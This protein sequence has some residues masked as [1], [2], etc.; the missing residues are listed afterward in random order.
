MNENAMRAIRLDKVVVNTGVGEAG[1]KLQKAEKVLQMVTGQK[2]FTTVSRSTIRDWGI[3][4]NMRIGAKVTLRGPAADAF[5]RRALEVRNNRLP[6][7]SFDARGNFSFGIADHTD[8][9]GM[10]YDPEIGVVGMDVSVA[11]R[12]PGYRVAHRRVRRR[13]VSTSHRVTRKESIAFIHS[14]YNVEVVE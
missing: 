12:R 13:R 11:L 5:L 6:A 4:R 10:K 9:A 2:A 7:Y 3:H 8:F 14:T 1:E